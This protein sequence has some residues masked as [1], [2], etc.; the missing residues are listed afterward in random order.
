MT[1]TLVAPRQ[2][3]PVKG[4][5]TSGLLLLVGH[6]KSGKT[7]LA[8]S[9]P[10]SYVL[11]L[12]KN[13]ADRVPF[14]GA[15][16]HDINDLAAFQEIIPLIMAED[17]IKTIVIDSIDEL[18]SW[19]QADIAKDAG[20]EFIGKPRPGVDSRQLWGEFAQRINGLTGYLKESGKLVILIAHCKAPEKDDQGRVITPAGINVSGKGGAYIAA[21]AEMIG[22]VGVR[23]VGGK[24]QHYLSFKAPSDLAIWRS[25]VDELQDREIILDKANPY[26]SI[27]AVFDEPAP[28]PAVEIVPAPVVANGAN[29]RSKKSK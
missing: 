22:F 11:E 9:F 17:E 26:K 5:P 21:Q 29:G 19:L 10:N 25:R 23:T 18:A 13:G 8:A 4:M 14:K 12:E 27:E 15:R 28:R 20:V 24:G 6:P 16:I 1:M 7:T 3:A 2:E